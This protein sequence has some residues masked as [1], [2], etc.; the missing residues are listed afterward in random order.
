MNATLGQPSASSKAC[1]SCHDGT[2]AIDSFGG[3]T[4]T[5]FIGGR[6]KIGPNL[7]DDHPVSFTYDTVLATAD[8]TL[9]DPST[10]TVPGLGGKT[11]A[12]G[13]LIGGKIE[14]SSCHDVHKSKGYSPSSAK[15][16]I[17]NNSGSA[18]CLTCHNK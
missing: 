13:M 7:S 9:F 6:D 15:L 8:G 4:G 3:K 14:C 10:K 16:L 12:Q 5:S 17:I 18:L 11:I 2:V 1:L